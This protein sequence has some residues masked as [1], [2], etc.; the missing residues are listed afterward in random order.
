MNAGHY[1]E[2]GVARWYADT[3]HQ[4]VCWSDE[5]MI[6][7][8]REWQIYSVDAFVGVDGP[9]E[10]WAGLLD[11]KTVAVDQQSKWGEPGTDDV[12]DHIRLQMAWYMSATDLPWADVAALV[13][14]NDLRI[15]RIN[16]DAEIEAVILEE[17]YKF[18]HENV[19][20]RVPPP[21]GPSPA[22]VEALKQMY[23]RHVSNIRFA[24]PE[25]GELLDQLRITGEEWDGV[26]NRY[27]AV[28][29][30][31]K[32]AIGEAEGLIHGA[33]KVTWR[34]EKDSTGADWSAIAHELA[35]R[36]GL[37]QQKVGVENYPLEWCETVDQMAA[38]KEYQRITR[39]G[40]RKLLAKWAKK[41]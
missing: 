34:R 39:M 18:W 13:G 6:H 36:L 27:L 5:T 1:F 30:Q 31:I 12:P 23:P 8:N 16:R 17:G 41:R 32:A 28:E 14:G 37:I 2:Q 4:Q 35:L 38:A 33:A 26:N 24:T 40:A 22:T 10:P 9:Y 29:N 15:Y 20:A 21:A 7:P 11:C 25:E 3:T 19:L